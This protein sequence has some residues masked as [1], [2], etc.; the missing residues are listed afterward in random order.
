MT[1]IAFPKEHGAYVVLIASWLIG[2]TV[3]GW[4]EPIV[5]VAL[6]FSALAVFIAEHSLRQYVK[7]RTA[8]PVALLI[9]VLA[10]SILGGI[11]VIRYEKMVPF[12]LL[13]IGVTA[14]YIIAL[15]QRSSTITRTYIG[16]S[17]LTLLAPLAASLSDQQ[18]AAEL[19]VLWIM[20]TLLYLASAATVNIRLTAGKIKLPAYAMNALVVISCIL[21]V[22]FYHLTTALIICLVISSVRFLV[23][24]AWEDRYIRLRVK[25]VG[26]IE[27]A[28]SLLF[29]V[30]FIVFR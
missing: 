27:S 30:A 8:I 17:G 4:S 15:Q 20:M 6:L 10:V 9:V 3:G 21:L 25:I 22:I 18:N 11:V 24:L 29:I 14:S 7:T 26:I 28:I 5:S 1:K 23:V 13:G 19:A 16:F 2:A 12:V